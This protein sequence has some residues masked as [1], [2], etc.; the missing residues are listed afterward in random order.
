MMVVTDGMGGRHEGREMVAK[1]DLMPTRGLC[2]RLI[3]ISTNTEHGNNACTLFG[4]IC[5]CCC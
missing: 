1:F 3:G 4:E 2:G 5:Y